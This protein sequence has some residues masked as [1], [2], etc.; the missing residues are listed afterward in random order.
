[1]TQLAELGG[2]ASVAEAAQRL[3]PHLLAALRRGRITTS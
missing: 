3:E 1:M 2:P